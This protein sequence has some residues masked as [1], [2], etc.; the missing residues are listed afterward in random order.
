M[1][2]GVG[3]LIEILRRKAAV[4]HRQ[5]A[6]DHFTSDIPSDRQ[7]ANRNHSSVGVDIAFLTAYALPTDQVMQNLARLDTATKAAT[8]LIPLKGIN[9]KQTD[10][11]LAN[12]KRIAIDDISAPGNDDRF[13]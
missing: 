3:F 10:M 9:S 6:P 12:D 5:A 4:S 7:L 11:L 8:D 2:F 13:G 1:R